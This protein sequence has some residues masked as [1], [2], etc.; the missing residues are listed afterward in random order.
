[1]KFVWRR[2]SFGVFRFIPEL[3]SWIFN[4]HH[5]N[6]KKTKFLSTSPWLEFALNAYEFGTQI[7]NHVCHPIWSWFL[8]WCYFFAT[9]RNSQNS[10]TTRIYAEIRVIFDKWLQHSFKFSLKY[11]FLIIGGHHKQ[12]NFAT[13]SH[14]VLVYAFKYLR[15][16]TALLNNLLPTSFR[17][18]IKICGL[19][20]MEIALFGGAWWMKC[21]KW[22]FSR[23]FMS[24][25]SRSLF[26]NLTH[27]LCYLLRGGMATS[28]SLSAKIAA[29]CLLFS[30]TKCLN[31]HIFLINAQKINNKKSF[32]FLLFSLTTQWWWWW[33][34]VERRKFVQS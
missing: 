26:Y 33:W 28:T 10:Q 34:W 3:L 13:Q 32:F 25:A 17:F 14:A 30:F 22:H 5:R 31:I 23:Y 20:K 6:E 11:S 15:I 29:V 1:M 4:H 24:F 7:N 16:E 21:F 18:L 9:P 2:N 19:L 27:F 12:Q 8:C